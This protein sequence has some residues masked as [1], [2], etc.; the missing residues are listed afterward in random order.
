MKPPK[1][2]PKR[3]KERLWRPKSLSEVTKEWIESIP[4]TIDPVTGCWIPKSKP[5]SNGYVPIYFDG[6]SYFLHRLVLCLYYEVDYYDDNIQTRHSKDCNK[7]CFLHSHLTPGTSKENMKDIV[8]HGNNYNSK[9]EVCQVCGG[10]Y[11]TVKVKSGFNRG[12][13]VR[14]CR[15]CHAAN[16][17]RRRKAKKEAKN[18]KEINLNE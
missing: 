18:N 5:N 1:R 16:E 7:A 12:K 17:A 11:H 3:R 6:R 15:A 10:P 13:I 8:L 9:K 2:P 14:Q 4:K